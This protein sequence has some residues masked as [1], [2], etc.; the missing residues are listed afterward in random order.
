VAETEAQPRLADKMLDY[1]SA[2]ARRDRPFFLYL[3]LCPPHTPIAPSGDFVGKGGASGAYGD[4]LSQGDWVL[5]RLLDAL[6]SLDL[7]RNTVVWVSSDNGAAGRSYPPL[8]GAKGSIYEGG[9]RVPFLA[10]WPGRIPAGT[11]CDDTVCLND[12]FA[13]CADL[14]GAKIPDHA[15]E[16]SVSILPDLLGTATMPVREATVH[17]APDRSMAIRQGSWKLVLQKGGGR[18]LYNLATDPGEARDVGGVYPET[19]A[20]L[21][22]LLEKYRVQGRSTPGMPQKNEAPFPA[23]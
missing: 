2:P 9:H 14:L 11:V 15:A 18:E 6:E 12:L 3:P 20:R 4:W 7:A 23:R 5:G 17:Q 8:R 22:A 1:L 10:R 13:T 19:V 16:D 21:A